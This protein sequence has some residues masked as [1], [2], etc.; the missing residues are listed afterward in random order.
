[1]PR[2]RLQF[3]YSPFVASIDKII[4]LNQPII[5]KS[6]YTELQITNAIKQKRS[7][8]KA[9]EICGELGILKAMVYNLKMRHFALILSILLTTC[10]GLSAQDLSTLIPDSAAGPVTPAEI[11]RYDAYYQRFNIPRNNDEKDM[12]WDL[13]PFINS[14][15][16]MYEVT[17][18]TKYI[19]HA[20]KCCDKAQSARR[21]EDV[22]YVTQRII[23]GWAYF[24][25]QFTDNMGDPAIYNNVVGNGAIVRAL[26]R[27]ARVIRRDSLDESYQ[28]KASAYVQ[29]CTETINA[30]IDHTEWYDSTARLFHFPDNSR[31][32]D[33]L[34]GVRGLT[35]AF[36]RQLL[37]AVGMLNV[38][39]YYELTGEET[40]LQ[41][42]YTSVVESVAN[43]FWNSLTTHASGDSTYYLWMYREE[44]KYGEDPRM[45]DIGHGGYDIK[46]IVQIHEDLGIGSGTQLSYI[47]N[48][49]MEHTQYSPYVHAFADKIDGSDK[50]DSPENQK[51]KSIRWLALSDWDGRVFTN[52]GWQLTN[53]VKLKKALSYA[54]FLY[55]KAK[56]YGTD[57]TVS[58]NAFCSIPE[59][60]EI[61]IF[62][63]P[64]RDRINI[65]FPNVQNQII[66]ICIIEPVSGR[67]YKTISKEFQ[68]NNIFSKTIDISNLEKGI[69]L[70][71]IQTKDTLISK[72]FVKI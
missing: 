64:S 20:I 55:Y 31:H 15:I 39:K 56:Y 72:K 13:S 4:N 52:A 65:S 71:V 36:N 68:T 28:L 43:Y 38:A 9:K 42:K 19:D 66:N 11:Y 12:T 59:S 40:A 7:D 67:L 14:L 46:C 48:T 49:L 62:P 1:M 22:D 41:L 18:D 45:E 3:L 70:I 44:G 10:V 29:S 35:S 57:F 21:T 47:G 30:F 37:M 24:F 33:C 17:R 58:N 5:N 25:E 50:Y 32:D 23:P 6:K 34:P 27:V 2:S 63:N 51:R 69:Y 54:E 53:G 61:T 26:S 60:S 16:Y 8:P